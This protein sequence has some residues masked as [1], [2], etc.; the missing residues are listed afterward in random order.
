MDSI[1]FNALRVPYVVPL[2]VLLEWLAD[3]LVGYVP[4]SFS[5]MSRIVFFIPSHAPGT[6]NPIPCHHQSFLLILLFTGAELC[7]CTHHIAGPQK[8]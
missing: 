6:H 2:D 8:D 7:T 4:L 5:A 3:R 1:S